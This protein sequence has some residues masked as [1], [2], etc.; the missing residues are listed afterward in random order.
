MA[1][2]AAGNNAPSRQ[3]DGKFVDTGGR[4]SLFFGQTRKQQMHGSAFNLRCLL[5]LGNIGKHFHNPVQNDLATVF[6]RH[7]PTSEKHGHLAAIAIFNKATNVFDLGFQIVIIGLGTELDFLDLYLGLTL[8]GFLGLFLFL[9]KILAIVHNLTD[10]RLGVGR[11]LDEIK[12]DFF[13]ALE[14]LGNRHDA[15]LIAVITYY[16]NL[17]CPDLLISAGLSS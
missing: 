4:G 15:Q 1:A 2:R 10:R 13:G 14:R 16:A 6:M 7:F 12:P 5:D 11:H 8:F 3:S 17:F 9:V